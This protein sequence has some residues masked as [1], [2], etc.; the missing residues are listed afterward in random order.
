MSESL[1]TDDDRILNSSM[2]SQL[3]LQAAQQTMRDMRDEQISDLDTA[4]KKLS[5][6]RTRCSI[7]HTKLF[8]IK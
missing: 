3:I 7:I 2:P 5:E 8:L 4:L 6:E 1:P